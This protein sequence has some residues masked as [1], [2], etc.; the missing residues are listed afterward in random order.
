MNQSRPSSNAGTQSKSRKAPPLKDRAG[1]KAL[2]FLLTIILAGVLA[3]V[4]IKMITPDKKEATPR[5]DIVKPAAPLKTSEGKLEAP[6]DSE[7]STPDVTGDAVRIYTGQGGEPVDDPKLT[8]EIT[9][10]ISGQALQLLEGR[11]A[12]RESA[13]N[14]PTSDFSFSVTPDRY[15]MTLTESGTTTVRLDGPYD[16]LTSALFSITDRSQ[17]FVHLTPKKLSM[18]VSAIPTRFLTERQNSPLITMQGVIRSDNRVV[19]MLR[20]IFVPNIEYFLEPVTA[21]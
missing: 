6:A 21:E 16:P 7:G 1:V 4:F 10:E 3:V 14:I 17:F 19:G 8:W 15:L 12:V 5:P 20:S 18:P 2:R 9:L 11:V 13:G